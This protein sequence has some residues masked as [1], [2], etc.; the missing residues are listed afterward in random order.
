MDAASDTLLDFERLAAWQQH[1]LG[2]ADV[3]FRTQPAFA[4]AGRERYGVSPDTRRLFNACLKQS[5]ETELPLAACAARVYLDVCFFHPFPD[6]NARSAFLALTIVLARAGICLDQVGPIRRVPR[7]ADNPN[8]AL[9]LANLVALLISH[10][11]RRSHADGVE[12]L[13]ASP[14]NG[15]SPGV[16]TGPS[17]VT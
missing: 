9:A 15:I 1:V 5:S 6:G 11:H 13:W 12:A 7:R 14:L 16:T 4:K 2:S 8:D 17:A 3:T 10:S